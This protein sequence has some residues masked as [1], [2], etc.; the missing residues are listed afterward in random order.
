[1]LRPI[2]LSAAAVAILAACQMQT[3]TGQV[4]TPQERLMLSQEIIQSCE[5]SRCQLLNLDSRL[6][7]DYAQ[8]AGFAHVTELMASFSDFNDLNAIAPMSQLTGLHIGYTQLTDLSALSNFPNLQLL[9]AQGNFEVDDFSAIGRLTNLRE[10]ALG[11]NELGDGAFLR[12]LR[13]LQKLSLEDAGLTSLDALRNHPTLQDLDIIDA[14][15]PDDISVLTTIPNLRQ[16]SITDWSLNDAQKAVIAQ[17][18]A[19]G[20]NVERQAVMIVC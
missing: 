18:E 7:A 4:T 10:L 15:L 20:V 13:R 14:T 2:L 19:R 11:S 16:I 3:N 17:L 12:N 5:A 6:V 1:M 8:I 9:H